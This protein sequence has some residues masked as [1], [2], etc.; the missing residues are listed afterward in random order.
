MPPATNK[1]RAT[2]APRAV[3][4]RSPVRAG[5]PVV[6]VRAAVSERRRRQ[7]TARW[8]RSN[9]RRRPSQHAPR[10]QPRVPSQ[11]HPSAGVAQRLHLPSRFPP[12]VS[13]RPRQW[14][15]GGSTRGGPLLA[16]RQSAGRVAGCVGCSACLYSVSFLPP[17]FS[18]VAS[19][20][21]V[22][23]PGSFDQ[24]RVPLRRHALRPLKGPMAVEI[25]SGTPTAC[26]QCTRKADWGF[27]AR[28]RSV[29]SI[30]RG[31]FHIIGIQQRALHDEPPTPTRWVGTDP[32]RFNRPPKLE[33]AARALPARRS[34]S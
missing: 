20:L 11:V 18:G 10:P 19:Q 25:A 7:G 4:S 15:H 24:V 28:D 16:S 26:T 1:L 17:R 29:P 21:K 34:S 32:S 27:D 23:N 12:P 33:T 13:P 8:Q 3:E 14:K 2:P 9:P 31:G 6:R 22:S 5:R 30:Q